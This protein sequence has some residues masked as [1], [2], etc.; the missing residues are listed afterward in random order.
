MLNYH[1]GFRCARPALLASSIVTMTPAC[2]GAVSTQLAAPAMANSL[3]FSCHQWS[4]V[5]SAFA[6]VGRGP[7]KAYTRMSIFESVES[8]FI[9]SE[10]GD[11]PEFS[12]CWKEHYS[13]RLTCSHTDDFI[14][15]EPANARQV[16]G[17]LVGLL[18]VY[19]H[20]ETLL[21]SATRHVEETASP[22]NGRILSFQP[23]LLISLR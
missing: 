22:V 15:H 16:A 2:A 7:M 12:S 21:S 17:Y 6:C 13:H 9:D 11:C 18:R 20:S 19:N 5:F 23:V 4:R 14:L 1:G 8:R 3:I 10:K